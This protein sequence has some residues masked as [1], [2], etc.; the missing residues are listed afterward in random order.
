MEADG[1]GDTDHIRLTRK[2]TDS[3]QQTHTFSELHQPL[4]QRF[5]GT[6]IEH[7]APS[8]PVRFHLYH[9]ANSICSQKVRTVLAHTG[10][11]YESHLINIFAGENYDPAYVKLRVAA[12]RAAGL[13]L[14]QQHL[15]STAVTSG[16]CDACVVPT[17][18]D[19][20]SEELMV[21]SR[22]VCAALDASNPRDP[23]GLVP[24]KLR[25]EIEAE[26][27]IVDELPNYQL[28]AVG[29]GPATSGVK[30][31]FALGKVK[32]CKELLVQHAGD[33]ELCAAYSAKM[34]K[35]QMAADRLFASDAMQKA[36]VA[37]ALALQ[38]LDER[39]ARS[40]GKYLFG[41]EVTMADLFWGVELIR[42][43]DLGLSPWW[44]D[45]QLPGVKRYF[46]GLCD[47][48]ALHE[49]VIGW[50]GARLP[51]RPDVSPDLAGL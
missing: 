40:E 29:V 15:G 36:Y 42:M 14:V 26:L 51:R 39:V 8:G 27:A 45:G 35:E 34:A 28:L 30:N 9:A 20:E 7:G 31:G 12:C 44:N 32:R 21:D 46:A 18:A 22:R 4:A 38:G 43:E 2:A 16:G 23:G 6:R 13:P 47:L 25:L 5:A 37:M 48:P 24:A 11:A 50:T 19:A 41:D 49:A 33:T 10:Q 17:L 1:D 3:M